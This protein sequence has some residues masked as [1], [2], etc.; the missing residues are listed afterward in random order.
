MPVAMSRRNAAD[1]GADLVD[2][3]RV[4]HYEHLD[5]AS[6]AWAAVVEWLP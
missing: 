3:A 4:G 5:P 2:F 6:A 1:S